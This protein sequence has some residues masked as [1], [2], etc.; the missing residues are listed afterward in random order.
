[1]KNFPKHVIIE[2]IWIILI[3]SIIGFT[4]NKFH[5]K[6]IKITA[7]RPPLKFAADTVFAI[8]LPTANIKIDQHLVQEPLIVNTKQ[9]LQLIANNQAVLIDARYKAEYLKAHI[10]NAQNIPFES[11]T[12]YEEELK[13]LPHN[14]WL[15]CYCE[16]PPCDL[17]ELLAYELINVG[18]KSVAIYHD[19]I[20]AWRKSGNI[21][22]GKEND[23]NAK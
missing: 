21:V 16:G 6:G 17:G 12:E 3:A 10:Q 5:P 8:D 7:K 9:V 22:Q 15:I 11:L 20:N 19:G 18:Y 4:V 23:K 1:M 13:S 14:K 2:A